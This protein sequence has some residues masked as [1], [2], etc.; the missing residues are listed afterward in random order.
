MAATTI[1]ELLTK[2]GVQADTLAILKFD[3][4]LNIASKTMQFASG[5]ASRLTTGLASLVTETAKQG[6]EAAKAATRIGITAEEMQELGFA[7]EQSGARLV[8]IEVAMRR[9]AT[10]ARDAAKGTGIAG[11]SY[12]KLGV[13]VL[14]ATG[15]LK[16]QLQLLEETAAALP[17]V[18]S[19]TEQLAII[20]DIFGRGGAKIRPLLKLG[21]EGIREFREEARE[22]GFVLD[23]EATKASEEFIDGINSTRL[24]LV[25]LRN[26]I[27]KQLIPVVTSM[28]SG[29]RDFISA[30][31]QII[32]QRIDR[33]MGRVRKA[34]D[35]A[36][37]AF[38]RINRVIVDE[39]GGWDAIFQQIDKA[40]KLSGAITGLTVFVALVKAANLALTGLAAN[41][42]TLAI[43]AAVIAVI[44]LGLAIDDLIVF[45]NGGKSVIG[46]FLNA[47]D[48]ALAE[49]FRATLNGL[50]DSMRDLE[51]VFVGALQEIGI[52]VESLGELFKAIFGNVILVEIE[53]VN[54]IVKG[55]TAGLDLVVPAIDAIGDAATTAL[56][57]IDFLLGSLELLIGGGGAT[58]G[59]RR[60]LR[61]LIEQ[62]EE[63]G[64]LAGFLTQE[65]GTFAGRFAGLGQ[66]GQQT[67]GTP[68]AA[69]AGGGGTSVVVQG[70][71]NTFNA[72]G[73]TAAE[74]E[75][76]AERQ[77]AK[78]NRQAIA[79]SRGGE[80]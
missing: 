18:K 10:A 28:L 11:E 75:A 25:G 47:M 58:S 55:L 16:P 49:E 13:N 9:Q 42:V 48:P 53:R 2:L 72:V 15:K 44:L 50:A 63:S 21:A 56:K 46:D 65:R 22:L 23:E 39:L 34:I 17:K 4:A 35:F 80:R 12:K 30:N 43:G 31:R 52:P 68:A 62:R 45:A 67:L 37:A 32:R 71:T 64:G 14:D 29:F 60:G 20:N 61:S 78:K 54:S 76:H 69:A 1:R 79:A 19:E 66:L 7:A 59:L 8:D 6:D 3:A 33:F 40:A 26:Q 70:D 27:G 77:Q 51:S 36:R 57:Q 41:P 24:V 5:V 38:Q 74:L 73:M